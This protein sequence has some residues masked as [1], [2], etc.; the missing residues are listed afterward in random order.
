MIQRRRLLQ[1]G[2][3]VAAAALAGCSAAPA[4]YYRIIPVPGA[5]LHTGAETIRVR[6]IGVPGYLLQSG[7]AQASGSYQLVT[8]ANALWAEPLPDMLQAVLVQNLTQRLPQM[9]VTGSSGM[10]GTPA[11]V[12]VE[13]D[14]LRFDPDSSGRVVL[15]AQAAL[16]SAADDRFLTT[17]T[18]QSSAAPASADMPG[19]MAAMSTLWAGLADDLAQLIAEE[20]VGLPG[21]QG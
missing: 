5:V 8:A 3:G 17:R 9:I 15:I 1:M 4:N 19:M 10:V 16:K 14:L 20:P 13:I 6:E 21:E 7:I 18:L 2:P 11:D 12:L